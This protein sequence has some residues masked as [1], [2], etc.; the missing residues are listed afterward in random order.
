MGKASNGE[1]LQR[2]GQRCT[3][4][5]QPVSL[6]KKDLQMVAS[7]RGRD[8]SIVARTR[9]GGAAEEEFGAQTGGLSPFNTQQPISSGMNPV[10]AVL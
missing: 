1:G 8:F 5:Q 9:V 3:R 7:Q 6:L 4:K 2:I 10:P